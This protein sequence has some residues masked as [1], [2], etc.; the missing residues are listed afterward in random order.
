MSQSERR[1]AAIMFT[2]IVGYTALTQRDESLAMKLLE[3]HREL[4]RPVFSKH[5]G[6][7]VKTIGDAFLV[8]F[9]SALEATECAVEMQKTLHEFNE[10]AT[11]RV[12]VRVGVH[13]GD[14]IHRD[15]DVYG[16]AVNI[17]S[18]IEP[19]ASAGG[20]CISEQVFDQVRNKVPY[21]LVKLQPRELKNV[22]FQIDVYKLDLPWEAGMRP[23]SEYDKHRLAVL[24][25]ANISPDPNDEYLADGMT[26]ELITAMSQLQGLQVLARTSVM[27]YKGGGTKLST[28]GDELRVGTVLEGSV[29][30]AGN[31]VRVTAQLIDVPTESHVWSDK[32]DRELDDIFAIQSD[33]ANKIAEALRVRLAP[34]QRPAG[35]HAEIIEAYT[36]YLKGRFYWNKR[37]K[38]GVLG[39]LKL[40]Q[41]AIGMDPDYARAYSGLADAYYIAATYGFIDTA[42]GL[43]KSN[44]AAMKAL[45]LNDMLAE[46]H[47]SLGVNLYGDLRYEEAQREL[48]R[49]IE[50]NPSYASAH[51]W[52]SLCLQ[53]M[54]RAKEAMEEI[55]KAH[56]LDPLSPVITLNV[57]GAH[58]Y[59]GRLD[60]AIAILDKLIE[61]EPAFANSYLYRSYGFMLKGMKERAYADLEAFR[62]LARDE[63]RYKW[64]HA[65]LYG[66]FGEGEK[67]LP[68][69]EELIQKVGN[70]SIL[71]SDIAACYA[72]LGDRDEFFNWIDKAISA[73]MITVVELRSSPLYD[74]VREDPRFPEIFKKLGLPY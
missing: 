39:S 25:F 38:E 4:I 12:L 54:G 58:A 20:I 24:P 62:K 8:E 61:N 53:D 13:V 64:A 15:G 40:F 30:K 37:D 49:A 67:A 28:I 3:R 44:E 9:D 47:A 27:N 68:M 43:A 55:E 45:E 2:D 29:R 18:R 48:R 11:N 50:L 7:E 10:T 72:V 22:A 74:K 19:L 35:K 6:R 36:L 16:D 33:I 59:Y 60:E 17:A 34:V 66:W 41:A 21:E 5:S 1:L 51:H 71:E 63:D 73:K 56:E 69:I 65:I 52:Y 70:S 31:R 23:E 57:G 32:Y 26:E 14:V 42:E 46:A